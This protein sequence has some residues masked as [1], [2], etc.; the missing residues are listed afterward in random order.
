[1]ATSD[2]ISA[3]RWGRTLAG[4][5]LCKNDCIICMLH[6]C[7]Q[8]ANSAAKSLRFVAKIMLLTAKTIG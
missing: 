2:I 3:P 6:A 5:Q 1:M 8:F 4:V 7:A